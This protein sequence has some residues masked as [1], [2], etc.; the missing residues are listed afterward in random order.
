MRSDSNYKRLEYWI[1]ECQSNGKL[2][3][4][5]TELRHAFKSDSETAVKLLLITM[6]AKQLN[7]NL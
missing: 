2:A 1:E 3:F 5:L 6:E 4:S 7:N